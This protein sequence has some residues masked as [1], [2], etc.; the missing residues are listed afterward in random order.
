MFQNLFLIDDDD[1]DQF[2]FLAAL[3]E[4]APASRCQISNNA[5]EAFTQL[6][7]IDRSTGYAVSGSEYAADE[8][9]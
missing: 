3:K 6:H 1:D 4:V 5:L 9:L 2:I 8:W 7:T